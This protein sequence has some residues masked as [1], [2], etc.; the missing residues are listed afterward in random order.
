MNSGKIC[1]SI[2]KMQYKGGHYFA[3]FFGKKAFFENGGN[4]T[5]DPFMRGEASSRPRRRPDKAS[6]LLIFV[7]N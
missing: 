4:G 2:L 7:V 6:F 5:R 3:C 1:S